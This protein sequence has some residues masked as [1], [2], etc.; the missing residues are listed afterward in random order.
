MV[1]LTNPA[2]SVQAG[3]IELVALTRT[4]CRHPERNVMKPKG[5]TI[6]VAF[7][8]TEMLRLLPAFAGIRSA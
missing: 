8:V 5:L 2:R 1:S 4:E 6:V 7:C 3:M